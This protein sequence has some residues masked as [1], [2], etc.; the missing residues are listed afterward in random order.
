MATPELYIYHPNIAVVPEGQPDYQPPASQWPPAQAPAGERKP[1]WDVT[2][3]ASQLYAGIVIGALV[4][5]AVTYMI[6]RRK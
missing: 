5:I 3:N 2:M 4:L 6:A 1:G